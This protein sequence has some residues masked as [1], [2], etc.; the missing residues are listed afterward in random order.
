MVHGVEAISFFLEKNGGYCTRTFLFFGCWKD[1]GCKG[2]ERWQE[3]ENT[4][5]NA[6]IHV[7]WLFLKMILSWVGR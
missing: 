5:F 6:D 7:D 1:W 4:T 3:N 2:E